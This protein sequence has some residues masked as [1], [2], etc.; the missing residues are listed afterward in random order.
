ME[1]WYIYM[2]ILEAEQG[3]KDKLQK[4]NIPDKYEKVLKSKL[5]GGN[6]FTAI[7]LR[8]AAVIRYSVGVVYSGLFP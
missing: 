3:M 2:G 7:I 6:T 8:A 1:N 4:K 5:D